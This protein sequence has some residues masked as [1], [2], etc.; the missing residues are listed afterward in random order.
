MVS[1]HGVGGYSTLTGDDGQYEV[2]VPTFAS[3]LQITS[4]DHSMAVLGLSANEEQ[5]DIALY[6]V[7]FTPDYR[8]E[9]NVL[10]N[11]DAQDF[12]YSNAVN[13]RE[14]VQKQLGGYV[15]GASRSG[16]P[17]M[18]SVLFM[19]GLNSLNANAQPLVVIDG[20]ILE[21]QYSRTMLHD[22]F[23]NDVLSNI[24]PADIEDISVMRNGTALYG[25]RG[26][27]GVILITTRRSHSMTTHITA[28]ASTG[29]SLEPKYY[30]MMDADQYRSYS[31]A[32]LGGTGTKNTEF[33]FLNSDPSYYY[34][35]QYHNNTDWKENVYRTAITQNYGIN[36]EGGD[37]VAQYNL[38]V[39]YTSA[40]SNLECN[41]MNRISVRFNTDIHLIEKFKIRFDCSFSNIKR[42]L[43]DDGAPLSYDEGTPTSPSFLAYVKSPLLSPDS[44][45]NGKLSTTYSDVADES[46]LDEA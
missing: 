43:R 8:P 11:H 23:Y 15:Y 14:E 19:Q 38:S 3:A 26:A 20:V 10:N 31:S 27:N 44:Y 6:A 40:Q 42:D 37:D 35:N 46:Y 17:G 24:N 12:Q 30:E 33:K 5:K 18:G 1:A 4:P 22:G 2:A 41:D 34:Y 29:I 28:R 13:I 7:V 36:V 25:T 45:G 9:L 16:I 39:G 21:Q 32:L